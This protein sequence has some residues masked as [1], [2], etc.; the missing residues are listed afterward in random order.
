MRIELIFLA[1]LAPALFWLTYH[2][3][4]DRH[5]PEPV[6]LL[7]LS[8]A[9]G[10]GAG[11]VGLK[12]YALIERLG[13]PS[14]PYAMAQTDKLGFLVYAVL[15]VGLLEEAV[16]L[17]PFWLVCIR[18]RAFDEEIDGVIYASAVA[19]GFASYENV[20]YLQFLEGAELIGRS[21]ASPLT[22]AL[23]ASIWGWAIGRAIARK[24]PLLP[25]ALVGLSISAVAHGLY[26]FLLLAAPPIVRPVPALII[27]A[28]WIWRMRLI[29]RSGQ[30]SH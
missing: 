4:K 13:A 9:L 19:L 10:V 7:I 22:H 21:V 18:L 12:A 11:F 5:R 28:I 29:A 15:A 2:Y 8:Y 3:Y 26:D 6:G 14:D 16:K 20:L 17:L 30:V 24:R 27:L 1:I 23:F 25:A